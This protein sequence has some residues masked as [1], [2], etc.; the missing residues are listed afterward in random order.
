MDRLTTLVEKF[1]LT[2][3]PA[4]LSTAN[5]I[6]MAGEDGTPA[7]VVFLTRG[8]SQTARAE[9]VLFAA[10]V[11]WMGMTNPLMASLPDEVGSDLSG[12]EDSRALVRLMAEETTANRC[13][14]QSVINR[15]G[16]ALMVRLLREQISQGTTDVGLL[17][18]LADPRISRAIVAMH[19][20]PGR[21]W[22]NADLAQEAGLSLSRFAELFA[23]TV[24]ETPMGYLRRWRLILAHQ[25]IMRGDRV[26]A[27]ARRYAYN[28]PES[29]TRAF[30]K[31][32]GVAPTALRA[33]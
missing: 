19:D 15:L 29:F 17:A 30:R 8:T 12:A 23:Q 10:H 2:V 32:H 24:G 26:D 7:R 31:A 25:D 13:G 1:H 3:Q 14:A 18:G 9:E 11:D 28:S 5:L 20:F 27:V 6:A 33:A 22:S 21:V 16:E 4:P